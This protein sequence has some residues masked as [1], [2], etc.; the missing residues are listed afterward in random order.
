M[1]RARAYCQRARSRLLPARSTPLALAPRSA[2]R[3]GRGSGAVLHR[4]SV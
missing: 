1:G 4:R 3:A 2:G